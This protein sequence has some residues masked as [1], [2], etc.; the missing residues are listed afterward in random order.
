MCQI[1]LSRF[2][3]EKQRY[4]NVIGPGRR[5]LIEVVSRIGTGSLD[6]IYEVERI[7]RWHDQ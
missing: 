5:W 7:D 3:I 2:L 4:R 1:T 6:S